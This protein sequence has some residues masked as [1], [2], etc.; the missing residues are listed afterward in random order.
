MKIRT[1]TLIGFIAPILWATSLPFI[2]RC[3]TDI[4]PFYQA[5][6]QYL[7]SGVFGIIYFLIIGRRPL[8][9]YSR[10]RFI[11]RL[12][13]FTSYFVLLYPAI[14]LVQ[15]SNFPVVLLLNYLWPTFTLLFTLVL[16]KQPFERFRLYCGTALVVLGLA[17]EILPNKV[18]GAHSAGPSI[19]TIPYVL[20][21]AAAAAWGLYSSFNRKWGE[22]AGGVDA[23]PL[24]MFSAGTILLI[25][26]M[27]V[28]PFPRITSPIIAPLIYLCLMPFAANIA[29]DIGTRSGN[30]PMLSLVCDFIPWVALTVTALYLGI[31]LGSQTVLSALLIVVGAVVS[32]FALLPHKAS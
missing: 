18:L 15:T 24:L 28:E 27:L 16:L 12:I 29:W 7:F 14:H 9:V 19:D 5:A 30:L 1:E 21:F 22:L 2:K 6:I 3:S 17:L 26:A 31:E 8:A 25:I 4:G 10:P 32:R 23:I 20:A 11:P 13:L